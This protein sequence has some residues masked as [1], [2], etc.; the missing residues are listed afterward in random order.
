VGLT[1]LPPLG[2]SKVIPRVY[3]SHFTVYLSQLTGKIGFV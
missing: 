2:V 1:T 3:L